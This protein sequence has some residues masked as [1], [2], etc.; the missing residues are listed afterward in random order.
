MSLKFAVIA[1]LVSLYLGCVF[2]S[3]VDATYSAW[4]PSQVTCGAAHSISKPHTVADCQAYI[5][6]GEF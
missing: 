5:G 3:A 2:A 4:C 6:H 1:L